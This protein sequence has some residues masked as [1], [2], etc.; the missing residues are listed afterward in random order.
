MTDPD[1]PRTSARTRRTKPGHLIN[2]ATDKTGQAPDKGRTIR[3]HPPKGVSESNLS[4]PRELLLVGKK[5]KPPGP[6]NPSRLEGWP[7]P[8]AP[9]DL[10]GLLVTPA[11]LE[12]L[13][14]RPAD[15]ARLAGGKPDA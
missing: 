14:F 15:L 3:T 10:E 4:E 5:E 7:C 1:K 6:A 11:T 13:R 2:Q 12:G 8:V 9:A